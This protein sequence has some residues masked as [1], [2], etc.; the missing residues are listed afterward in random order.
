MKIN[1]NPNSEESG[2]IVTY[3]SSAIDLSHTE[4]KK[5]SLANKCKL[6]H[7][8]S[9]MTCSQCGNVFYCSMEHKTDD[10]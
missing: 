6:C 10:L 2:Q 8:D 1:S 9:Q 7:R 4:R 3:L 5:I